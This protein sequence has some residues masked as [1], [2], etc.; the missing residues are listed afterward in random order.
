MAS[1]SSRHSN[2]LKA[3]QA[4]FA[5]CAGAGPGSTDS[6]SALPGLKWGTLFSGI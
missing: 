6:R 3:N 4:D 2:G 5:G 1:E